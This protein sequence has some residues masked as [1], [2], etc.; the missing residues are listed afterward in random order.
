MAAYDQGVTSFWSRDRPKG[1]WPAYLRAIIGD[2]AA[3]RLC[4]ECQAASPALGGSMG[5]RQWG[6]STTAPTTSRFERF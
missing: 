5:A 1:E 2:K 3:S 4:G 6:L